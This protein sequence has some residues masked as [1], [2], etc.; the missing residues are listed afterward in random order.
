MSA[1]L[2][3]NKFQAHRELLQLF[4]THPS[5]SSVELAEDFPNHAELIRDLNNVG[6][7]ISSTQIGRL[8]IYKLSRVM[9][10]KL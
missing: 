3:G 1:T 5:R 2:T 6:I 7:R 10:G 9:E 4:K 8:T